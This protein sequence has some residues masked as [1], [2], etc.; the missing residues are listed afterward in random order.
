MEERV[1]VYVK[2]AP[3]YVI[4]MTNSTLSMNVQTKEFTQ[5]DQLHIL[6]QV[7][8]G[9][10]AQYGYKPISF[11]FKE[12]ALSDLNRIMNDMSQES[13]EFRYELESNLTYLATF[14]LQDP[15][16]DDIENSIQLI[17]YGHADSTSEENS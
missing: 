2:G 17:R 6:G 9:E 3:E 15:L 14:G 10:M 5:E 11:A 1:R 7:V 4:P 12:M 16:I 8:S 13:D